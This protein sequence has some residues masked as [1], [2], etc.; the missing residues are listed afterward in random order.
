M[1]MNQIAYIGSA[2]VAILLVTYHIYVSIIVFRANEYEQ[3]QRLL[4]LF[5][6]WI[7]PLFGA[8][9]C[10]LVLRSQRETVH[11]KDN[12][13]VSQGPNDGGGDGHYGDGH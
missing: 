11:R 12:L 10:H 5:I 2:L 1:F 4:Q 8:V 6:V 13:F 3:T 7:I 9:A